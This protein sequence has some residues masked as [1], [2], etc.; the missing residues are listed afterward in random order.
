MGKSKRVFVGGL[1][2]ESDT[3]NPIVTGMDDIHVLRGRDLLDTKRDDSISGIVDTLCKADVDVVPSLMA[4]AVPNG[5]WDHGCYVGLRNELLGILEESLPVD[6][7]CLA[8][9]GSMRVRGIGKSEGDL[10]ARIRA[11][12]PDIPVFASLDMHATVDY[13]MLSY[14]DG[15]IG[16]KCA[17]HT[18]EYETGCLVAKMTLRALAGERTHMAAVRIPMLIAGEQSETG[19]EP[20]KSL[21]GE[22]RRLESEDESVVSASYLLGFPWADSYDNGVTAL[23][24]ASEKSRAEALA[25]RLAGDFWSKRND[26]RFYSETYEPKECLEKAKESIRAGVCPVVISDSG[27]NPTA[28]SSQDVTNF[29]KLILKDKELCSL[30]PP[31]C[32]QA[33][34]DPPAV[35]KSFDAGVGRTIGIPLGAGFDRKTSTPV[36]AEARVVALRKDWPGFQGVSLA[37]LDIGGI[38]VVVTDR[39][40]GCYDPGMM[41]AL[42]VEPS[43]LK[44]CVVKLGY[45]EPEIRV[46]SKRSLMALSDGGSNE[47]FSRL[48]YRNLPRPI[49]PLDDDVAFEPS[50]FF[51]R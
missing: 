42:G 23:V 33:F 13:D 47:V 10:L 38:H 5:E 44:A 48:T 31:L 20:M 41:R 4:R 45:L 50:V 36:D 24:C 40:V 30:D 8:L 3:F 43:S 27:D 2:H 29:L 18:D 22:L 17:P 12:C 7:V 21:M 34:Y 6:A 9:H 28:G 35:A 26:F 37:L 49:F 1:H 46:I 15:F 16:Y 25:I 19:T 39:H 11:L 14:A 51:S 32:Y